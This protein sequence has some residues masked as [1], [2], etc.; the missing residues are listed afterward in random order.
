MD[1]RRAQESTEAS[2]GDA[3]PINRRRCFQATASRG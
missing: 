3:T 1:E 2:I